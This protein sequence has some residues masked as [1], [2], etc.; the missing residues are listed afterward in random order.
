MEP[1][2]LVKLL[3]EKEA[4]EVVVEFKKVLEK[5]ANQY[6]LDK[7]VIAIEFDGLNEKGE[8]SVWLTDHGCGNL[9]VA[10]NLAAWSYGNLRGQLD[11]SITGMRNHA[12]S[13]AVKKT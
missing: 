1:K 5:L 9:P 6:G 4:Q 2:Q 10:A 3:P 11:R 7:W 12:Y 13:E 8:R